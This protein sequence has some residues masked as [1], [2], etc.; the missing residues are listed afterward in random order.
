MG[1]H[2]GHDWNYTVPLFWAEETLEVDSGLVHLVKEAN[3]LSLSARVTALLL[4]AVGVM[5]LLGA[6]IVVMFYESSESEL[7]FWDHSDAERTHSTAKEIVISTLQKLFSY[8]LEYC[9][10]GIWCCFLFIS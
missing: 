8:I 3:R 4:I 10:L 2:L 5:L 7:L 9:F 1:R 6:L